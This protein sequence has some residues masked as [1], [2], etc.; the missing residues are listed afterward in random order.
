VLTA[1]GAELTVR[2]PSGERTVSIDDFIV[3]AYTTQMA[4]DE[5]LIQLSVPLWKRPSGGAYVKFERR[6]GDFAVASVGVQ[7]ELDTD[8]RC[9]RMA[10]ALGAVGSTPIRARE[11][12]ALF[13]GKA[14]SE[15]LAREAERIV[16]AT[17]QPFEDTRGSV[18]YKR[19]LASVL[20]GKAIGAALDRAR[21][22]SVATLH[23]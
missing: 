13:E 17:A 22:R 18:E 5:M 3:D 15:D 10:V 1:V 14:P 19:H 8:G 20:F 7:V 9:R 12:E 16:A 6:A 21:G 11:V 2:G 4:A 23:G